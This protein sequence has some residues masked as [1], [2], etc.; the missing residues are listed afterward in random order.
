M[1]TSEL[2]RQARKYPPRLSK[3]H[4]S[5]Q[6]LD[7]VDRDE[8]D[9]L[10]SDTD[11][12]HSYEWL[13]SLDHAYSRAE[14]LT[15]GDSNGLLTG[16]PLWNGDTGSGLFSA[17][18]QFGTLPGPWNRSFLWLGARRATHSE[19]P[20]IAGARRAAA[21]ATLLSAARQC[22][23]R[24]A[25]AGVIV[26]YVPLAHALEV[27]ATVKSAEV[28][29][30]SAEASQRVPTDGL[31]GMLASRSALH[32][33]R[34]QAELDAFERFGNRIE[35][36]QL[37]DDLV[38]IAARLIAANRSKYGSKE[39][40]QWIR[41]VLSAQRRAGVAR[42]AIAAVARRG[43]RLTAIS[44]FY[45]F[46]GAL[47]GR[48]FGSDY[49]VTDNDFRYFVLSYYAP[50]DYA[51]AHGMTHCQLSISA[52]D[53]K[54]RRGA[55]VEPLAAIVL[56]CGPERLDRRALDKHNARFTQ[57]MRRRYTRH[58]SDA[59]ESIDESGRLLA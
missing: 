19:M 51:S 18:T 38:P 37:D 43:D 23:E 9:T 4:A 42:S 39:G 11:F 28:L 25:C 2:S 46:R 24:R 56:L 1:I 55:V 21:W 40:E 45:R 17:T 30:H 5:L 44:V 27:A 35:W 20:C 58:L 16:V 32:R 53:A 14:L 50:L 47:Y 12:F 8:W 6:T 22:A 52:L 57:D 49:A 31:A 54:I 13:S 48:Y 59:W 26:P 36:R 7:N 34:V 33:R 10:V 15:V 41:H 29:L 3:M